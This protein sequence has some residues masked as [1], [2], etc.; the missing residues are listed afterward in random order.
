MSTSGKSAERESG[1]VWVASRDGRLADADAVRVVRSNRLYK[2]LTLHEAAAAGVPVLRSL[3]LLERNDVVLADWIA[4][5]GLPV[6]LRMDYGVLPDAKPLGG[7]PLCSWPAIATVTQRLWAANLYPLFQ[8]HVSRFSDVYSVG[9]HIER[10]TRTVEIEVVGRGFD[11]GDLRLGWAVPHESLRVDLEHGRVLQYRLISAAH[12][13]QERDRRLARI[14]KW[15]RYSELAN[16]QHRLL[17]AREMVDLD[18]A[19][20]DQQLVPER[21]T[22]LPRAL[23]ASV[24]YY[25]ELLRSVVLDRLPESRIFVGSF[26]FTES[27]GWIFWDIYGGW[28]VRE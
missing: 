19:E 14:R 2:T 1:Q 25:C 8:S 22:P 6:M 7:V 5:V 11:A 16:Q 23:I 17:T 9:A 12:Y 24:T 4:E 27:V 13:S 15:Q 28:Y 21:Y 20:V 3:L 26:S 10:P 18:G